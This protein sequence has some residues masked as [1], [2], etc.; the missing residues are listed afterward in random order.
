MKRK[1]DKKI[2]TMLIVS[3]KYKREDGTYKDKEWRKKRIRYMSDKK[4]MSGGSSLTY[5]VDI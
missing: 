3:E 4:E 2:H 5:L 1:Q